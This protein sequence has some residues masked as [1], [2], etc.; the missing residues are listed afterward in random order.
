MADRVAWGEQGIDVIEDRTAPY[1]TLLELRRPVEHEAAQLIHG[2]LTGNVLFAADDEPAVID[3]SPY[4]RPPVFAEAIVV[5]DG[6]LWFD[7]P[8]AC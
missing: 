4:W 2:D 8:A 7:L 6:L 1:S 5:A 3:F